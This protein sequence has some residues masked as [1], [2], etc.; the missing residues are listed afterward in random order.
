[1]QPQ[2]GQVAQTGTRRQHEIQAASAAP[3]LI[4]AT[5]R[6]QW[7]MDTFSLRAMWNF[8]P[9]AWPKRRFLPCAERAKIF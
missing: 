5:V 8:L 9:L 6:L 3:A 4:A 7:L 2:A 1:L